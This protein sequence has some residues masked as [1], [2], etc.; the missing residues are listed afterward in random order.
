[1]HNKKVQSIV[2]VI[3]AFITLEVLTLYGY[4]WLFLLEGEP[5][6][7]NDP[8]LNTWAKVFIGAMFV[9]FLALIFSIARICKS[10]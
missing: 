10:R 3:A 7:H 8:Q 9:E 4:S 5:Q 1:M 6:R 2:I